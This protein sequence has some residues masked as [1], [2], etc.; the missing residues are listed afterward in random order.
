MHNN[1][2]IVHALYAWNIWYIGIKRTPAYSFCELP[3]AA[4]A[5]GGIAC[6]RPGISFA[7]MGNRNLCGQV[8]VKICEMNI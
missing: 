1:V 3:T 4:P 6:E 2:Y 5:A 8:S 7:S